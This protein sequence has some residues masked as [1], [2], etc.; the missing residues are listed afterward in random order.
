VAVEE[1][2]GYKD[3]NR[4]MEEKMKGAKSQED[5]WESSEEEEGYEYGEECEE[6]FCRRER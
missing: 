6:V 2:E 3:V 5:A 4:Y 1:A